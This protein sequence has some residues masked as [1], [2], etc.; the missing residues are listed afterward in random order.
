[1][2]L[3]TLNLSGFK[4]FVDATSITIPADFTGIVGPNGCGKSNVIDAVRWVMG[5]ASAR[6]LRGESMSDVIFNGSSTRKP[7]GKAS[8]ELLFD[9]SEGTAPDAYSA[10]AEIS[11]RRTL[12]RDGTS[13]Y[14]INRARCRRRDIT[15]LFR[16]TGLGAR[17]Y[18]IIEQGMVSRIVEARPEELRSFVEEAAGITRYKDRRRETET[19]IRH[20]RENLDR[21]EDIRSELA[22]QLRRLQRQSQAARRYQKL[23]DEER[24][25]NGQLLAVR[26]ATMKRRSEEQDRSTAQARNQVEAELAQQRSLESTV[27]EIRAQ[28]SDAQKLVN[29]IQAEFYT[30]GAEVASIEQK[31]EHTRETEQQQRAELDRLTTDLAAIGTQLEQDSLERQK[32][33]DLVSRSEGLRTSRESAL[34]STQQHLL[35]TEQQFEDWQERWHDFTQQAAEP[36]MNQEVQRTRIEQLESVYKKTQERLARLDEEGKV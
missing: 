32:L 21:I 25:V 8:V 35:D 22:S 11:V 34:E 4:S 9:N 15:D 19:R 5:E 14:Q 2:R 7:V 12:S 6:N 1:M 3:K 13:E 26:Y 29:D 17:S 24:V 16:G 31:I 30:L 18:S 27:E 23:R 10:F 33:E 28:Q 20:T 36:A